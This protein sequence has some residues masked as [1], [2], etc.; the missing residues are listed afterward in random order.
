[1]KAKYLAETLAELEGKKDEHG[2]VKIHIDVSR[3]LVVELLRH[4]PIVPDPDCIQPID[5]KSLAEMLVTLETG[6]DN[7]GFSSVHVDVWRPYLVKL[8]QLSTE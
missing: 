1:M 7:N 5:T 4:S 2:Y 3:P 6:K 8:L